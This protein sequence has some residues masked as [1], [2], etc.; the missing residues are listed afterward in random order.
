[1]LSER[2][3]CLTEG[4]SR[5]DPRAVNNGP[6]A[7]LAREMRRNQ[8][9]PGLPR[10]RLRESSGVVVRP[11]ERVT[12]QSSHLLTGARLGT[13]CAKHRCCCV[14]R[15]ECGRSEYK[16]SAIATGFVIIITHILCP[17]A[18]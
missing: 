4:R 16:L 9:A 11:S 18:A 13:G 10:Q 6:D 8:A 5:P 1:M 12:A 17:P 15:R 14:N 7:G 2:G 3:S